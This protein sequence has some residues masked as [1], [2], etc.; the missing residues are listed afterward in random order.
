MPRKFVLYAYIELETDDFGLLRNQD[1]K[2][3]GVSSILFLRCTGI[4]LPTKP[5]AFETNR[6]LIENGNNSLWQH[7]H[8]VI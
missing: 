3:Q 4:D 7:K 1:M 8:K 2:H 6:K 5:L